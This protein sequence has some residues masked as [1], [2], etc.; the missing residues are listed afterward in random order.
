M[1]RREGSQ[2]VRAAIV[3]PTTY[4][5]DGASNQGHCKTC[6]PESYG[7]QGLPKGSVRLGAAERRFP[8]G[9]QWVQYPEWPESP[10]LAIML[11]R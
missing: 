10:G 7:Y 1:L 6:Y 11:V 3:R 4:A 9:L 5:R 8:P 2:I